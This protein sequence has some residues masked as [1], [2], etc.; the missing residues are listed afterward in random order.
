MLK[1]IKESQLF[2][3]HSYEF[4]QNYIEGLILIYIFLYYK[5]AM[6]LIQIYDLSD[7]IG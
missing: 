3:Q 5:V 7:F 4:I 1:K 6:F 2:Q